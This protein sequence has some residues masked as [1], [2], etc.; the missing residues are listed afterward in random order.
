MKRIFF[1]LLTVTI[2]LFALTACFGTV[3]H[4]YT[5]DCDTLCDC[6][7]IPV[8]REPLAE[9]ER[10]TCD[11]TVCNAC[12]SEIEPI[13]HTYS[14]DCDAICDVCQTARTDLKHTYEK[15]CS[16]A[17]SVCGEKRTGVIHTYSN[18]C[19]TDCDV[20]GEKRAESELTHAWLHPC[21]TTCSFCDATREA[22]HE[23]AYNCS[24]ACIHCGGTRLIPASMHNFEFGCS[25]TCRTCGFV[26]TDN[27]HLYSSACD[28]ICDYGCGFERAEQHVWVGLCNAL[29]CNACGATKS[30]AHTDEDADF[31]CDICQA[32][33]EHI[34]FNNDSLDCDRICAV[35]GCGKAVGTHIYS[36]ACDTTCDVEGCTTGERAVGENE[37]DAIAHAPKAVCGTVCQYCLEALEIDGEPV[38]HTYDGAC[39]TICNECGEQRTVEALHTASADKG[40]GICAVCGESTGF[41]HDFT[42]TCSDACGICGAKNP[43]GGHVGLYPCSA[44]CKYCQ[45][46]LDNIR[47]TFEHACSNTC[48]LCGE[49][50]RADAAAAHVDA[51]G[52]KICDLCNEALPTTGEGVLPEHNIPSKKNDD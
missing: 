41:A 18:S 11:S 32:I 48:A 28:Q 51:D 46:E 52:D 49:F 35:E 25:S 23:Y 1:L 27:D 39:D 50:V 2:A 19:D 9:H 22:S 24:V 4:Q 37:G 44:T 15:G 34:C 7:P 29:T 20:C 43:N 5:S 38:A 45:A 33:C 12:R 47:H 8:E 30:L 42:Y 31:I 14:S 21:S 40:C 13:E 17:C 16:V 3:N 26:R 10:I 6:C 36:A